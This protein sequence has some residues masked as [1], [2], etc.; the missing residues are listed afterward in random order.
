MSYI[1]NRKCSRC[2]EECVKSVR[3]R[4]FGKMYYRYICDNCGKDNTKN[5][6]EKNRYDSS[7]VREMKRKWNVKK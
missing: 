7:R 3:V 5:Q 1:L 2:R 4:K 6:K